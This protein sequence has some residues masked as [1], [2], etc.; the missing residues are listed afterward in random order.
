MGPFA[1]DPASDHPTVAP[2]APVAAVAE[3]A[4]TEPSMP[5]PP[6]PWGSPT[7]PSTEVIARPSVRQWPAG[8]VFVVSVLL[9][10]PSGLGLSAVNDHR[11][12]RTYAAVAALLVL[13]A[14]GVLVALI[15]A[16]GLI[17]SVVTGF[18]LYR[19]VKSERRVLDEA[20]VT[21]LPGGILTGLA[22]IVAAWA[23]V[24]APIATLIFLGQQVEDVL[25]GTI[26]F[27]R[28]GSGCVV[29]GATTT[30]AEGDHVHLTAH[31]TRTVQPGETISE[32]VTPPDG[33]P[34]SSSQ[35]VAT[36]ADCFSQDLT[37]LEQGSYRVEVRTGAERLAAGTFLVSVAP[38]AGP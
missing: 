15:P 36:S 38:S 10:F 30:F 14:G 21:V 5:A 26:E 11:L 24:I 7:P 27:G 17:A 6:A 13:V 9:G 2:V 37:P 12:G 19:R 22:T 20:G 35:T 23:L 1:Q 16:I 31:F 28:G 8:S 25:A 4:W 29:S 32:T 18:V 33:T 3:D 34:L